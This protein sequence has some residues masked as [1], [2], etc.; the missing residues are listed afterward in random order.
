MRNARTKER[1]LL[2][3]LLQQD[4]S[5]FRGETIQGLLS[6]TGRA[7]WEREKPEQSEQ[8][9]QRFHAVLRKGASG[10]LNQLLAAIA[11]YELFARLCQD[12]FDDS[13]FAM[14]RRRNK[15]SP[16]DL[17]SLPS[18]QLAAKRIPEIFGSLLELLNPLGL[19]NRVQETFGTLAEKSSYSV[20]AE[21]LAEHHHRIQHNKPPEGKNAWFERFDDGSFIIRP[22]YRRDSPGRNNGSYV[23][24]YRTEPLS[25]FMTDLKLLETV[26]P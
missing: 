8:R 10:K 26:R 12:A 18:V 19:S 21:C 1:K 14:T 5:G 4:H 2:S 24:P 23:H 20:W 16:R 6:R 11:S 25:S 17:A 13:I 22:I 15:T 9:E 7:I 3:Q